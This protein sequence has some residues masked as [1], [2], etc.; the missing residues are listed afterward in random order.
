MALDR[1]SP[2]V[3]NFVRELETRI[4]KKRDGLERRDKS[5]EDTLF[6]RGE[7]KAYRQVI[8]MITLDKGE[9]DL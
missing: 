4:E 3:A 2:D 8:E 1:H 6:L 9:T 5:L 7:I